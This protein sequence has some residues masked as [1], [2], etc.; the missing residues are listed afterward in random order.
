MVRA[1]RPLDSAD[2]R[3][4]SVAWHVIRATTSILPGTIVLRA[5]PIILDHR[6]LPTAMRPQ[7]VVETV[8]A[9]RTP[10]NAHAMMDILDLR[11]PHTATPTQLA[12]AMVRATRPLDSADV[13]TDSVAWHVI[14][15]T[16]STAPGQTATFVRLITLDHRALPTAIPARRVVATAHAI[17]PDNAH[18]ATGTM[19][20]TLQYVVEAYRAVR[21]R[22]RFLWQADHVQ[23]TQLAR[24]SVDR[25]GIRTASHAR[26][27]HRGSPGWRRVQYSARKVATIS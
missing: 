5:K 15:A 23:S 3:T 8:H 14:R 1:T 6:A 9:I 4:D 7:R 20:H 24:V 16:T 21:C 13:R 2:V 10:D 25:T 11:A 17:I 18:A 22:F 12:Q 26:S 27:V 19:A